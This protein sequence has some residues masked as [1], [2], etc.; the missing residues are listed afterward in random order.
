MPKRK[1]AA[2]GRKLSNTEPPLVDPELGGG[3]GNRR[4]LLVREFYEPALRARSR[5]L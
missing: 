2:P 3:L 1:S 4:Q 5:L